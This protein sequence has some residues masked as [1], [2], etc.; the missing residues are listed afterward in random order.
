MTATRRLLRLP[1]AIAMIAGLI[2]AQAGAAH[3]T[4]AGRDGRIAF[5]DFMTGQIYAVNP[6]GTG[7]A[8]LTHVAK[9]QTAADPAWSPDGRHIAF[10]SNMSGA[11]PLWIMDAN[12]HPLR[13]VARGRPNAAHTTPPHTPHSRP[14]P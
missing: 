4:F 14:V 6:D 5:W 13:M 11:V 9:G 1:L 10:D 12:G 2:L 8:Q 3:A 7:L